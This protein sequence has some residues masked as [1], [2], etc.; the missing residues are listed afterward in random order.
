MAAFVWCHVK[1]ALHMAER[2]LCFE[3]VVAA[4]AADGLLVVLLPPAVGARFCCALGC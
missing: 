3:A 4:G 2:S 1:N